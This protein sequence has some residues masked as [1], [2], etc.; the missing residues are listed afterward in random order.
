MPRDVEYERVRRYMVRRC[1]YAAALIMNVQLPQQ[2][3]DP[4]GVGFFSCLSGRPAAPHPL[5]L[6][7]CF[8]CMTGAEDGMMGGGR[9]GV[10]RGAGGRPGSA[11]P[12]EGGAVPEGGGE[13]GPGALL[14]D[15]AEL[16]LIIG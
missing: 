6:S 14:A 12:A 4:G 10:G 5:C 16:R 3:R 15:T 8:V 1:R 11:V 7:S 2:D 9:V 13:V